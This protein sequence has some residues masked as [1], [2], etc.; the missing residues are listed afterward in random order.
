MRVA[1]ALGA[2]GVR[3][4]DRVALSFDETDWDSFA[5]AYL[6]VL[7]AGGVAVPLSNRMSAGATALVLAH[8]GA[9][10][11]VHAGTD[12]DQIPPGAAP[13]RDGAVQ[14]LSIP[15]EGAIVGGPTP[16]RPGGM[17]RDPLVPIRETGEVPAEKQV[18]RHRAHR[19]PH[20]MCRPSA[21]PPAMSDG[22]V[23]REDRIRRVARRISSRFFADFSQ[24]GSRSTMLIEP[25]TGPRS[26]SR[27]AT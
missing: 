21:T 26:R 1:A 25:R 15:R 9:A 19:S 24:A 8:C 16:G 10:E 17:D 2:L 3:R 20:G 27:A 14:P 18:A 5:V 7:T 13:G 23:G 6:G 12:V 11:V 4:G 22:V